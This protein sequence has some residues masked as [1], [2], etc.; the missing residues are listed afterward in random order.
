ML[1]ESIPNEPAAVG[2]NPEFVKQ[3]N[4][5]RAL[6][7]ARRRFD[8]AQAACKARALELEQIAERVRREME[9]E[10][11][12]ADQETLRTGRIRRT[13]A[14]RI[15]HAACRV[16]GVQ[17]HHILG[18]CR[19]SPIL[20]AR[21]FAMYWI[22]RRTSLSYPMIGRILGGRDHTTILHGAKAYPMKRAK[23]GRTL[24]RAR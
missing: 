8:E 4:A 11:R 10:M 17:R 21:Q 12:A 23:Q 15:I 24:R 1:V 7:D 14:Q 18:T 13:P 9:E 22:A 6:V 2:Y 19:Q 20:D 3:V 5:R 16:F